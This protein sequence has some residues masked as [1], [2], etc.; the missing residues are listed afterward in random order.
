MRPVL[1]GLGRFI[2]TPR[3]SKHRVFCW[4]AG[5]SIPD[6]QIV[7][8]ALDSD[9]AMGVLSSRFHGVYALA[10]GSRLGVGND[11]RYNNA[12]CFGSFPFPA[13]TDGQR[14][15][16]ATAARDLHAFRDAAQ[17]RSS[18]LTLTTIYNLV[19]A[20]RAGEKLEGKLARNHTLLATDALIDLHDALDAAVA[21]AYGWPADLSDDQILERLVALNHERAAE[22]A[23]GVV[24]WLRPDRAKQGAVGAAA[25]ATLPVADE[26][27]PT[28]VWPKD[29]GEQVMQVFAAVD[30]A[31]GP[32]DVE[33]IAARF[34]GAR[35]ARVD[36]ILRQ[37][38]GMRFV[39]EEGGG[40]VRSA[41]A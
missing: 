12:A 29:R 9:E 34:K 10:A 3:L 14:D 32:V 33:G 41:R 16:I 5:G 4:M 39:V 28:L 7:A 1:E 8:I 22:E 21:D 26:P 30:G 2:I 25:Q 15:R 18:E 19:A 36:E 23:K 17:A 31:T 24:R 27:A 20:R 13:A 37:L 40:K 35:R 38:V 6:T 11:P